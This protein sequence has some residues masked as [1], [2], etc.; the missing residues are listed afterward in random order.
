MGLENFVLNCE[1]DNEELRKDVNYYKNKASRLKKENQELKEQNK[2][3]FAD[4]IKFKKE[5]YDEYLEK[6][7]KL[8]K[9]NQKLK[10]KHEIT[11][12]IA[13][14]WEAEC[15]KKEN[16]QKKFIKYLEDEIKL[17]AFPKCVYNIVLQKYKSIIG[18]DK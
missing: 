11:K 2:K 7:N 17:G 10:K 1:K 14:D 18:D 9:E 13:R 3:E 16:Q 6:V 5:Q 8:I 12:K 15:T 4:Y